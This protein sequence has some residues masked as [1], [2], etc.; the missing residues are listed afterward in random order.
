M[1][2]KICS[3][4]YKNQCA[5]VTKAGFKLCENPSRFSRCGCTDGRKDTLFTCIQ[6]ICTACVII[7]ATLILSYYVSIIY[8]LYKCVLYWG[9]IWQSHQIVALRSTQMSSQFRV[10]G[11]TIIFANS[12][13]AVR[14]ECET[15]LNEA[16]PVFVTVVMPEKMILSET[17]RILF[18]K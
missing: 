13:H 15:R 6:F 17:C 3:E 5:L 16:T 12:T 1:I 7:H 14:D 8:S 18:Q 9:N 4:N 10:R 11:L 2:A